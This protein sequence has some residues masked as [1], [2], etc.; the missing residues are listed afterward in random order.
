[1][2]V[3]VTVS[4]CRGLLGGSGSNAAGYACRGSYH[5]RGHRYDEA[6]PGNVN[7]APGSTLNGVIAA[8]DPALLSTP[9]QLR[10]ERA[11]WRAFI[12]PIALG[13][14]VVAAVIALSVRRVRRRRAEP[15]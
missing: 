10:G 8:G 2:P 6:I 13:L 4:G 12:A 7:R 15:A 3:T 11:S 9:G 1:V 5:F 14:V